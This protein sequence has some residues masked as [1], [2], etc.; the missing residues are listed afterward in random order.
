MR[1]VRLGAL[2][3]ACW[4]GFLGV[5]HLS[6]QAGTDLWVVPLVGSGADMRLGEPVPVTTRAGYDNQPAYS[7]DGRTLYYTANVGGQTDI[8]SVEVDAEGQPLGQPASFINTPES[9]YS[10]AQI[11]GRDRIAVVRVE[12]DSAQRLWSFD[13]EGNHPHLELEDVAPVGYHAWASA[14]TVGLFVLGSPPRFVIADVSSGE[15]RTVGERIGRSLHR[16]PGHVDVGLGDPMLSFTL[17]LADETHVVSTY[18]PDGL[19]TQ[20]VTALPAGV[21]DYAWMPDRA[22][23]AGDGSALVRWTEGGGWVALGTLELGSIT[24]IAVHPSGRSLAVVVEEP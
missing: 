3:M 11:P 4:S 19:D 9:E 8:W 1:A 2:G 21:Q 14:N 22:V 23:V 10:A 24:R 7:L 18:H 16:V 6:A 13:L 12:A 17:V 5:P 20:G 15:S